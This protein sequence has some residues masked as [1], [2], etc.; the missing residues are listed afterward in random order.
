MNRT[1]QFVTS[2]LSHRAVTQ[3]VLNLVPDDAVDF[4]PWD[5]AMTLGQLAQH[6]AGAA[7]MFASVVDK[8][9]FVGRDRSVD[10]LDSMAAVRT[11]FAEHTERTEAILRGLDDAKLDNVI[12]T[13]AVFGAQ[14]PG[15]AV[16]QMMRDHEIHHKGQLF[17]YARMVGVEQMP[18]FVQ[19]L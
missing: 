16:L 5:N 2:W 13:S 19:R 8:G 9:E 4:R 1:E 7:L 12:D 14:F 11:A 6:I 10:A 15:Y 17:V 3:D 18:L